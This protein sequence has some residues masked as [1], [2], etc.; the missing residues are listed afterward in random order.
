MAESGPVL[1]QPEMPSVT[2]ATDLALPGARLRSI[3]CPR[4]AGSLSVRDGDRYLRCDR[5]AT[6]FI[7]PSPE[8]FER[9]YFPAKIEKL[10]AVGRAARWLHAWDE[11]PDDISE[12]GF[13]DAR[14][15][16][17]PIWEVRAYVVG[18]EFGK[19]VRTKAE[20]IRVGGE[21]HVVTRLVEESV[22]DGFLGERR[23]YREATD[24]AVLGVG[25]PHITG[26]EFTMPYLAGEL[27]SG[28]SVLEADRDLEPVREQ[29][30]RSFLRPPT[31]TLAR[32]TQL[33]LIKESAAL[34][35]YP[36]WSL[37]Y[38]YQGRVYEMTIDG[39]N[40]EVHSARAPAD[41]R[42]RLAGLVASCAGL[43]VALALLVSAWESVE[44]AREAVAYGMLAVLVFA[45]GVFW[46]F[47][48]VREVEHHETF[49]A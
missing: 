33:F 19:K 42:A 20:V 14:L 6:P 23:F 15:L 17:V 21:E 44:G 49:S 2:R 9:R 25:R 27:E 45:V 13:I 18:W 39:R 32:D 36:L 34:L 26:R 5:C 3:S 28:A 8:G 38:S 41:N 43:A 35:Y 31:G 7:L 46:R 10:L 22:E 30:R 16:Y 24:L 4:C 12:A 29:A 37:H 48:L 47:R 11:A 1:R 40:G